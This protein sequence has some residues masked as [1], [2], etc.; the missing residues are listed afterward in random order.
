VRV[1]IRSGIRM[2]PFQAL[3]H[4][5]RIGS[6]VS[7]TRWLRKFARKERPDVFH[8]IQFRRIGRQG[9]QHDVGA[10]IGTSLAEVRSAPMAAA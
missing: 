1:A 8:R 6:Y 10:D 4:A 5:P 2:S 9:Q 3:R 7:Q